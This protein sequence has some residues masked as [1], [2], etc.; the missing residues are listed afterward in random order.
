MKTIEL[1]EQYS[2]PAKVWNIQEIVKKASLLDERLSLLH[3]HV[4]RDQEHAGTDG[5]LN[6]WME[7]A[8]QGDA[9][10][11]EKRLKWDS[12]TPEK[13]EELLSGFGD[14]VGHELPA[15]ASTL[16]SV[17]ELA[18]EIKDTSIKRL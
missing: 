13:A 6:E 11:F 10:M 14:R 16:N 9:A 8:A 4:Q 2:V 7:A 1:H 15:W 17:L 5:L 3:D 18:A 12:I